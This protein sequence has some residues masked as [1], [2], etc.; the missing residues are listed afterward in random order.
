MRFAVFLPIPRLPEIN[1]EAEPLEMP[2][3]DANSVVPISASRAYFAIG[4][5]MAR[6]VRT[7]GTIRQ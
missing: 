1:S 2:S 5:L 4:L 6:I 3:R 7:F